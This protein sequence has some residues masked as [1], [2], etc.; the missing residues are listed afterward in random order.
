MKYYLYVQNNSGGEYIGPIFILV[1]AK[2]EDFALLKAKKVG[3]D[4]YA[5]YCKCCGERWSKN[6]YGFYD[7]Y[8]D[9]VKKIKSLAKFSF[10]PINKEWISLPDEKFINSCLYDGYVAIN[11]EYA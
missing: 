11:C 10:L 1:L 9:A 2:D 7:T 6:P 4:I 8:E 5:P 3:L